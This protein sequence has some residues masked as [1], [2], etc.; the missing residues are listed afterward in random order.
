MNTDDMKY[1]IYVRKSSEGRDRQ[2]LSHEGQLTEI[3]KII[4]R[5]NLTVVDIFKESK[6]AHVPDNRPV[7][8][9]MLKR[10]RHGEANGIIAWH[11]NRLSRNPKEGG[12]LQQMLQ[13]EAIKSIVV[14]YRHFK[15]EDN[16][17]LF[18]IEASEANQSSRDLKVVVKRGLQLK[19]AAGQ[20]PIVARVGYLNTKFAER[21]TNAIIADPERWHLMRKAFDLML[22]GQY[23]MR[24]I[25]ATLN[26]DYNFKTRSSNT[27]QGRPLAISVLH[28]C[29]TDP[30]Y[31]GHFYYTGKLHK[32]EYPAMITV[33]EYDQIQGI[34]GRKEK[35]MSHKHEFAFTGFIKCGCCGCAVTA[36]RKIKH[37]K[38]TGEFK[39]YSF[40]H[41]T[42][43][44]GSSVCNDKRYTTQKE[45]ETMIINKL[46]NIKLLPR[47]KEWVLLTIQDSYEDE[48]QKHQELLKSIYDHERKLL[49]EID[50]LLD[51]R[52]SNELSDEKYQ[53][54]KAARELSLSGVREKYKRSEHN[55]NEWINHAS[56]ALDFATHAVDK[57]NLGVPKLQKAICDYIGWNWTLTAKNLMFT[58]HEWFLPIE[59][60]SSYY[61]QEKPA[62]ELIKTFEEY[63][64]TAHY[65][66]VRSIG[67]GLR[68][69]I[70]TRHSTPRFKSIN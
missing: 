42:K 60:L 8:D 11:T 7:F 44:R 34:L 69:S 9:Q 66:R 16:S 38:A 21:G 67:C 20:P 53:Q 50:T 2:S 27:R 51:L 25:T 29:F 35:P 3:Q 52:I 61:E 5:E 22:T 26:N 6:S 36:S 15:S 57:F 41:C 70:R 10:I 13:D 55:V 43:R 23:T 45:M 47:W 19:V 39:A 33:E 32:G 4:E 48:L 58:R 59:Q 54:K 46:E 17:L 62:L 30:F 49:L 14:P 12:I 68:E 1:F 64:E 28:R 24:Q 40:Y 56:E 31:T 63:R 65:Q 18:S 37:I